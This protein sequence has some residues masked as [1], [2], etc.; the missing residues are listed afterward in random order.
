[1]R[2]RLDSIAATS[3]AGDQQSKATIAVALEPLHLQKLCLPDLVAGWQQNSPA[4]LAGSC[5]IC[6][7]QRSNAGASLT[8]RV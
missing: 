5:H 4:C 8:S 1:M 6:G 2:Q 3:L 7:V